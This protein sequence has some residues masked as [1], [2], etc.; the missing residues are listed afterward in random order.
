M[1]L[2]KVLIYCEKQVN[3][4]GCGA[5]QSICPHNCISVKN[6]EH[7]IDFSRC[8]LCYDCLKTSKLRGACIA[9]NYAP[10]RKKFETIELN[11][12][13]TEF[14]RDFLNLQDN[15]GVIITRKKF[16]DTYLKMKSYLRINDSYK[17]KQIN[18]LKILITNKF[19]LNLYKRH[20]FTNIQ[21]NAYSNNIEQRINSILTALK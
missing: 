2:K 10:I 4:V 12:E 1:S 5:C 6:K 16:D 14:F 20:G 11:N 3:C 15:L 8:S 9:R 13:N 7:N 18:E 21:I 19:K 17:S